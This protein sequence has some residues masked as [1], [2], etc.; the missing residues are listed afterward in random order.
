MF[1]IFPKS[2][3]IN[4]VLGGGGAKGMGLV[5][6]MA[7]LEEDGYEFE[8]VAGCSIGAVVGALRVA[9]MDADRLRGIIT[10]LELSAFFDNHMAERFGPVLKGM[11]VVTRR[12]VHSGE[13]F[14]QWVD[15]MLKEL[16]VETF[17]DL[18][19]PRSERHPAG[20]GYKLV[21]VAA[22]IT[23]GKLLRLPWDYPAMG[24]DPD[25]QRVSDALRASTAIPF[26]FQPAEI[27][28]HMLVDGG[29]VTSYPIGIFNTLDFKFSRRETIGVQLSLEPELREIG[30]LNSPLA[31]AKAMLVT[32]MNVQ[33]EASL[34]DPRVRKNTIYVDTADV[35]VTDFNISKQQQELLYD[36]G[37]QAAREFLRQ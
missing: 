3:R 23:G 10:E 11:S 29:L 31:V 35:K 16:G 20:Y 13:K 8:C 24:L 4:L 34:T 6:A 26:I 36:N 25:K 32:A 21:V 37:Y 33:S 14:N 5:G 2:K 28:G 9:G 1:R 30:E 22:D 12:G 15:D 7:A 19:L 17:G 18:K 27:A